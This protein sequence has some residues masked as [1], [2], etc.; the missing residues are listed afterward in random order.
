MLW[1]HF[2]N[3][4]K[5]T[6]NEKSLNKLTKDVKPDLQNN[7]VS[8][9]NNYLLICILNTQM[10]EGDQKAFELKNK[11]NFPFLYS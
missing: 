6:A 8:S 1:T 2:I 11:H 5:N 9:Y 3:P 4:K 10:Y 7:R